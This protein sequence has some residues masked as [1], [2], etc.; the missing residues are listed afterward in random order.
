[1]VLRSSLACGWRSSPASATR[2]INP[3]LHAIQLDR[4][5]RWSADLPGRPRWCVTDGEGT[6]VF[7]AIREP[8]MIFVAQLPEL[9]EVQHWSLPSEG[10]HGLDIDHENAILYVA[11]DGASL[12]AVD[13]AAG[14]K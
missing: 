7:L 2:P 14:E 10:A 9:N 5:E 4:R 11:C 1:M 8:S 3:I 6:R 13:A 12:V